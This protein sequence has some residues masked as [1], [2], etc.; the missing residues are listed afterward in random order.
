MK[1]K[2][3]NNSILKVSV[4]AI[5]IA[6]ALAFAL[7]VACGPT[8][9]P[10]AES[11]PGVVVFA[12]GAV[13][14]E[15]S[16]LRAGESVRAGKPVRTGPSS[17]CELMLKIGES[18]INV[19]LLENSE[20]F[21]DAKSLSGATA[22]ADI[23][24]HL[25]SG[26]ALFDVEKLMQH[27]TFRVVAPSVIA[28]VRGTRFE[29]VA[30]RDGKSRAAVFSGR[31]A[32]RMRADEIEDLPDDVK[33]ESAVAQEIVKAL[34]KEERVLEA[35]DSFS[36]EEDAKSMKIMPE[37]KNAAGQ[38]AVRKVRSE[39]SPAKDE[40][41]AAARAIDDYFADA[42][43]RNALRHSLKETTGTKSTNKFEYEEQQK[44]LKDYDFQKSGAPK[45]PDAG[46]PDVRHD[47]KSFGGKVEPKKG[48]TPLK[49][50]RRTA[51]GADLKTTLAQYDRLMSDVRT[52]KKSPADPPAGTEKKAQTSQK[53]V[54]T[55][56][57]Q[58][59]GKRPETIR[60]K[61]GVVL[62]GVIYQIGADYLILTA[63]GKRTVTESELAE[64]RF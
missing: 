38:E 1:Q 6:V 56:I 48:P 49:K 60:L 9:A 23:T 17:G 58:I 14:Q 20:F 59:T 26:R 45:S 12:F 52:E 61:S 47:D 16:K 64:I 40:M 15:T 51:G 50:P 57:V 46:K 4:S 13:S 44:I 8:P 24:S 28:S 10:A 33:R 35:G 53:E 39:A 41:K 11:S 18:R 55:K 19:K 21:I 31:I 29:V 27:A 54:M 25:K 22:S 32:F 3:A 34:E 42:K 43:R 37:L 5:S 62:Y 30:D 2:A 63:T 7:L 36:F